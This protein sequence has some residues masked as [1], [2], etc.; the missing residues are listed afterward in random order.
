MDSVIVDDIEYTPNAADLKRELL[1]E[2][3]GD[4]ESDFDRL[5]AE[6]MRLARPKLLFRQAMVEARGPGSVLIA[7]VEFKSHV[8]STNLAGKG[9][10]IAFAATSGAEIEDWAEKYASDSLWAYWTDALRES[11]LLC[12]RNRLAEI[13]ER[14]LGMEKS[15][16]M[17][18]GSLEDWPM[19][20][21]LPLFS[22]LG[23]TEASIG[24]RLT[25]SMLM[26][27]RKSVSGI[28]FPVEERFESCQLCPR[29]N[30]PNRRLPYDPELAERRFGLAAKGGS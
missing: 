19:S 11:A 14:D 4:Y 8:L 20:E 17:N 22:I 28:L 15:S 10:V 12:A 2:P 9:R 21:Q 16:A 7:G 23:D 27:P 25:D 13:V 1:V 18:P 30:C 6:A 24:L 5:F 26:I 3:G 29:E